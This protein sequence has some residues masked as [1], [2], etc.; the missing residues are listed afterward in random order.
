MKLPSKLK[1]LL[2]ECGHSWYVEQGK[3]H[4]HLYVAGKMI[5]VFSRGSRRFQGDAPFENVISAVRRRVRE[6]AIPQDTPSPDLTGVK[7]RTGEA[8]YN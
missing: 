7:D 3:K 8:C 5:A 1:R 4:N 2:D 6:L